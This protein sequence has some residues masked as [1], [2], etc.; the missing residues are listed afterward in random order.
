MIVKMR[1]A[2]IFFQIA[3]GQHLAGNPRANDGVYK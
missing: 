1:L 2:A 3:E